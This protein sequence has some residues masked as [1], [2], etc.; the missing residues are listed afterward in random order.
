MRIKYLSLVVFIVFVS[1]PLSVS[2]GIPVA[3]P[4][5]LAQAIQNAAEVAQ[6]AETQL[7]QMKQ[8]YQ[9]MKSE[10]D[11]MKNRFEGNWN[12][13]DI[14][15]DPTLSS[16]MPQNWTDIYSTG[17]VSKLRNQY[18]LKSTDDATQKIYD[19]KLHNMDTIQKAYE[20]TVERTNNIDK[21]AT[22][23]N[24]AETPQQKAD[25]ANRILYEQTQILNEKSKM[26]AATTLMEQR[27]TIADKARAQ[28]WI[29]EFGSK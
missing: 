23:M 16:Y 4:L 12:L 29:D 9:Q 18:G 8:Q 26:D 11:A 14:L 22:Y 15:N 3:D 1:S 2:A 21:L 28:S 7:N 17:D 10:A 19:E 13:G 27:E 6:Q 5:V 20:A 24:T 25:Y